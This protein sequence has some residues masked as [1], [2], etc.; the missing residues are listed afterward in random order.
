MQTSLVGA[1]SKSDYKKKLKEALSQFDSDFDEEVTLSLSLNY[2]EDL[3]Y[4]LKLITFL[5]P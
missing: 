3:K 1:S 2:N 4:N 5:H